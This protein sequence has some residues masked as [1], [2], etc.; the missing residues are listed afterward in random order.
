ML[1]LVPLAL[2]AFGFCAGPAAAQEVKLSAHLTGA[3]EKP[4][5]DPKGMGHATVRVDAAKSQVCYDLMVEGLTGTMAHIHKAAPDASGPVAVP[6]A[7]PDA[8][9]KSSGCATVDPA[10]AKDIAT[11]PG[12]YYVNVHSADFK[13]GAI[14]GQLG[15]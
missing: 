10:V 5:G 13:A 6:L 2:A 14:R 11:N 12:G 1:R 9:G 3:A 15:K 8:A 7:A 4:A